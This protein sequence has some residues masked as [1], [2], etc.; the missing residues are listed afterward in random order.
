MYYSLVEEATEN[1]GGHF[2]KVKWFSIA[3]ITFLWRGLKFKFKRGHGPPISTTTYGIT[4]VIHDC[5][6]NFSSNVY[7]V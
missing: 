4:N 6:F 7:Q 1:K 2:A 5:L 3:K